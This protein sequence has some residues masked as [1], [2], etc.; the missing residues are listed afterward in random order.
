[1]AE[2]KFVAY[3]RVSTD[4]QGRS[5]LGLEAQRKA[6]MDHLDGGG[7]KLVAEHTEVEGGGK[8][9]RP[10]LGRALEA[11]KLLGATLVIAKL[12]RLARSV[13]LISNLMESGV[14]F[15]AC[16]MPEANRLTV[17]VMAAMAE[18]ERH[19]IS[20][21]TREALAAAKARGVRLGNPANLTPEAR[22]RGAEAGAVARTL[23]ARERAR[24]VVPVIEEVRAAGTRSLNGIAAALNHRGIPAPRGGRWR[25]TQVQRVLAA[26]AE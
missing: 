23:K 6:V 13:A 25:A 11:C 14:D 12:D 3:Y 16:D 24:L 26:A 9:D 10:E 8:G 22:R 20:K 4:K 2:G 5:G 21:R 7:W 1:M 17:H 19:A 18:H 15:V